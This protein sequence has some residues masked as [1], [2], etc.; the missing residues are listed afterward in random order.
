MKQNGDLTDDL[1]NDIA[2]GEE[3]GFS[4]VATQ[5]V[6][7]VQLSKQDKYSLYDINNINFDYYKQ[8]IHQE[9]VNDEIS[10]QDDER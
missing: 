3:Q 10:M 6:L 9:I 2:Y 5:L 8:Q 4:T 7:D 1:K